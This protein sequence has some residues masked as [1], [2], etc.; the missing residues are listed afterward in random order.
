MEE[1]FNH[2]DAK[3]LAACWAPDGEF[4]GP[5]GQRIEGR[6][7][8]EAAFREFLAAHP[9]AKLQLAVASCRLLGDDVAVVDLLPKLTPAPEELEAEPVSTAV[10]VKRD[11]RWMIGS[12]H[13]SVSAG[14]SPY[15][16]LRH[17][18]WMVGDWT[19]ETKGESRMSAQTTCDWTRNGSYL[20][21]KFTVKRGSS[22]PLAG[23]EVIGWDPRGNRI[24][25][26]T[27]DSNGGF[28]ESVWTRD[29]GRWIVKYTGTLADGSDVSATHIITPVGAD[30][31]TV[32]F[33]DRVVNGEKQ[34]DLPEATLKR[35]A[36]SE[37]K[38]KS[39][40]PASPPRKVLP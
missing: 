9:N 1:S 18:Q 12:M 34:P 21:R 13:E 38:S 28:G 2:G 26:W 16:H 32:Q 7:K 37:T 33:K 25:S 24:R 23:T 20:I 30:T 22:V 39:S 31:I 8:I 29:D 36:P 35:R 6:E 27:F 14:P 5:R 3:G 40:E 4:V 19:S 17:L 10:L 15:A 11:G